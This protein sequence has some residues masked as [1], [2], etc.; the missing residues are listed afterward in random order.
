MV[1]KA[2]MDKTRVEPKFPT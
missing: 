1:N 2:K